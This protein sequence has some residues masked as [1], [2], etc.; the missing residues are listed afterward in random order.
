MSVKKPS[1][2]RIKK[3]QSKEEII[4]VSTR[5]KVLLL[6]RRVSHSGRLVIT[7][8]RSPKSRVRSYWIWFKS[9]IVGVW[10]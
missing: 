8:N 9:D 10:I 4:N 3:N 7:P 5:D 1:Q 6:L 2:R